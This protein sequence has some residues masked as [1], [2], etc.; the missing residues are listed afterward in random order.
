MIYLFVEYV[1]STRLLGS[2]AQRLWEAAHPLSP[3][4]Q[5][6]PAQGGYSIN[7][8]HEPIW[9]SPANQ[10]RDPEQVTYIFS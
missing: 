8:T 4:A 7:I 2:P 9:P 6:E 5:I 1:S 10:H 3:S